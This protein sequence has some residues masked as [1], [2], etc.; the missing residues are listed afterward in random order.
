MPKLNLVWAEAGAEIV[1]NGGAIGAAA[2]FSEAARDKFDFKDVTPCGA[3]LEFEELTAL[4]SGALKVK[5]IPRF[6]AIQR[7]LSIVVA[8]EVRWADAA[9]AI[10]S[11]APNELEDIQFVGIYRGRGIPAGRKSVTLS[12]RFRDEDGTLTHETVDRFFASLNSAM[13]LTA[14]AGSSTTVKTFRS[15]GEIYLCSLSIF[16]FIHATNPPQ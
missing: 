1:V 14:S 15:S 10:K 5:P 12:L 8:E 7:D 2:I 9:E 11:R 4:Q 6:P 13:I 3:E 16:C